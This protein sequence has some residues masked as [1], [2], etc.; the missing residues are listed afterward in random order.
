MAPAASSRGLL[1][2]G[3]RATW[4]FRS[5][6]KPRTS[7]RAA[8]RASLFIT[9]DGGRHWQKLELEE[10]AELQRVIRRTA[11]SWPIERFASLVL[12]TSCGIALAWEDPWIMDGSHSHVV[13][14]DVR[15]ESW[16]YR[17]LG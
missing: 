12:L 14:S 7:R 8:T 4:Q 16:W 2:P 13:C 6:S 15:G 1:G 9:H 3:H 10:N 5:R 17:G 11:A